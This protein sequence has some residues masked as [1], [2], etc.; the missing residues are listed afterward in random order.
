MTLRT[1]RNSWEERHLSRCSER[2]DWIIEESWSVHACLCPLHSSMSPSLSLHHGQQKQDFYYTYMIRHPNSQP[3]TQTHTTFCA[4][5]MINTI[6]MV[7]SSE[8]D[9]PCPWQIIPNFFHH[10]HKPEMF[11]HTSWSHTRLPGYTFQHKPIPCHIWFG[12]HVTDYK[13]THASFQVYLPCTIFMPA[14][15]SWFDDYRRRTLEISRTTYFESDAHV[16]AVSSLTD[17]SIALL[18]RHILFTY[19]TSSRV[20]ISTVEFLS[21]IEKLARIIPINPPVY[22]HI[23]P[24]NL[25]REPACFPL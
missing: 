7:A 4:Q 24:A 6:D 1:N 3:C 8:A 10:V 5:T 19:Y 18:G 25:K 22:P 11:T 20:N 2:N 14:I 9:V 16:L 15:T 23:F 17:Q 13:R 21:W 12:I